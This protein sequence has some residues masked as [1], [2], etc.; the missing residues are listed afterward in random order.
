MIRRIAITGRIE[1]E[2]LPE[3]DGC[4][5]E[6]VSEFVGSSAEITNTEARGQGSEMKEDSA[7]A[8]EFHLVT[9]RIRWAVRK[10]TS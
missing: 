10:D 9:I 4:V 7:A 8:G 3:L 1:R 2:D 5:G 6:K